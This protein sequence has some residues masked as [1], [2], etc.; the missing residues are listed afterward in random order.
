MR[1]FLPDTAAGISP[2]YSPSRARGCGC[3]G[4]GTGRRLA[5]CRPGGCVPRA[6][7]ASAV[8]PVNPGACPGAR[9]QCSPPYQHPARVGGGNGARPLVPYASPAARPLGVVEQ[10]A[11]GEARWD[12]TRP[13]RGSRPVSE[14]VLAAVKP[15]PGSG[16]GPC[17]RRAAARVRIVVGQGQKDAQQ[18]TGA[19]SGLW[20]TTATRPLSRRAPSR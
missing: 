20:N 14:S 16:D 3:A 4:G 2:R 1:R 17:S 9:R 13:G 18:F 7:Q 19:R 10:S 15:K 11:D 5:R 12:R 8:R 6:G